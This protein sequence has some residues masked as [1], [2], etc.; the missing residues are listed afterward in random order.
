VSSMTQGNS[1]QPLQILHPRP[2]IVHHAKPRALPIPE[3][4]FLGNGH[5]KTKT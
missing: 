3:I 2:E 4:Q 5:R 1:T